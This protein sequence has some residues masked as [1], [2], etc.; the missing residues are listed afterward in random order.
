VENEKYELFNHSEFSTLPAKENY[1]QFYAGDILLDVR[2]QGEKNYHNESLLDCF[3]FFYSDKNEVVV[4]KNI[5]FIIDNIIYELLPTPKTVRILKD[6][7]DLL[8]SSGGYKLA[9]ISKIHPIDNKD[10]LIVVLVE[11]S[12]NDIKKEKSISFRMKTVVK[13]GIL[14]LNIPY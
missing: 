11:Y 9:D 5:N 12:E 6:D 1:S 10:V 8:Y 13:N 3:L 2:V 14:R 4:I 7:S